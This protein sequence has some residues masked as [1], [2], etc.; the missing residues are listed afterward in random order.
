MRTLLALCASATVL[1]AAA[2]ALAQDPGSLT[3]APAAGLSSKDWA[4]TQGNRVGLEVDLWSA[5]V[6]VFVFDI[7]YFGLPIT[8]VAQ[9]ELIDN[10]YLDVELPL[11]I[12]TLSFNDESAGG[13]ALGNPTLGAHYAAPINDMISFYAGGT[14]SVTT[15]P[16]TGADDDRT[17]AAFTTSVTRA[18]YDFHRY[19]PESIPI[20]ARGGVEIRI[21]PYLYYRGELNP[22]FYI[23]LGG[24]EAAFFLEQG[25]E[26]EARMPMGFGGG[27]RL[28]EVFP[29]VV[30][31][32][33][34]PTTNDPGS[35]KIQT[36]LEP[37]VAY[38]PARPGVFARL[39]LLIALDD[40]LGFGF[41]SGKVLT[42]RMA[43]GYKF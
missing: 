13:F 15:L 16:D 4:R 24:S 6:N 14:V 11:G 36:A 40:R 37:F 19:A 41:D 30:D 35:D 21:L 23:P 5:S 1:A 7:S 38:E 22:V 18:F 8:P 42:V 27:L 26:I 17:A 12:G 43:G 34:D 9:I 29:L 33:A 20:R 2:P 25:N 32:D 28:Q 31:A 39:G 10:L 3:P